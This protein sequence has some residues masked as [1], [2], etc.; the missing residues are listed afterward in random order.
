LI[1][2]KLKKLNQTQNKKNQAKPEKTEPNQ[3]NRAKPEPVGLN[4]IL[5]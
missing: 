2:L 4:R 1:S 5:F 3:K